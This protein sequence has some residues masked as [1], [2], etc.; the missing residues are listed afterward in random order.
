MEILKNM[1]LG[2]HWKPCKSHGKFLGK[3]VG[4]LLRAALQILLKSYCRPSTNMSLIS[5]TRNVYGRG[6]SLRLR[7]LPQR[8]CWEIWQVELTFIHN[9]W[10]QQFELVISAIL[11]LIS[12]IKCWYQQFELLI[13][14]I[15]MNQWYHYF[16]LLISAIK[17]SDINNSK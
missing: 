13:S 16:E 1:I 14:I 17:I 6:V 4:T 9:Y 7:L 3:S 10:Y 11:L 5:R 2:G 12:T 8:W 15:C